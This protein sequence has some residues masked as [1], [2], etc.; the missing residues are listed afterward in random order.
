M[1]RNGR[2]GLLLILL[3]AVVAFDPFGP[4]T[5]EGRAKRIVKKAD[6]CVDTSRAIPDGG[7]LGDFLHIPVPTRPLANGAQVLD[8]DLRIRVSHP[9]VGELDVLL[10]T[11]VGLMVPLTA[12][13]G[14]TG[15]D[16]GAGANDC[17][18]QFT[19]FDDEAPTSIQGIPPTSAP[20]AAGFRP[21]SPL[22]AADLSWADGAWRLYI[23]DTAAG[24][25]GVV[26]ALGL[27]LTYRCVK[28]RKRCR[29]KPGDAK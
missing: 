5:A 7:Q 15:D 22:A 9:A 23:D 14:G 11:P 17:G 21:E 27:N 2:G 26:E 12:G 3:A 1:S 10:V 6:V 19:V 8:A 4:P 18:A 16:F 25:A 28:G 24:S 29:S 20:F 13:N